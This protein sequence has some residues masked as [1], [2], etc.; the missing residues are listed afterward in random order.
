MDDG[1]DPN[2]DAIDDDEADD[3]DAAADGDPNIRGRQDPG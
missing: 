1:P 2:G 3:D